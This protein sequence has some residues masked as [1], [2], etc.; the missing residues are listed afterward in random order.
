LLSSDALKIL[1][2]CENAIVRD[3]VS[4]GL[5]GAGHQTIA[6]SEPFQLL[7][8]LEAAA[9]LVVDASRGRQAIALLRDRGFTGRALVTGVLSPEELAQLSDELDADGTLALDPLEDLAQRFSAAVGS[10]RRVLIVDDSE[11]GARLLEEELRGKGFDIRGQT[12]LEAGQAGGQT[13]SVLT[14]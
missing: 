2:C 14:E 3:A 9:A 13:A 12:A 10:R 4:L 1:I 6:A 7:G 8:N 11:I 5:S